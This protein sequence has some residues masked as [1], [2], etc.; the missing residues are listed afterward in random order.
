MDYD[1]ACHL[2]IGCIKALKCPGWSCIYNSYAKHNAFYN[3][4]FPTL[5]IQTILI[6]L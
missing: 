6:M 5:E 2:K 3:T 1:L 4:G